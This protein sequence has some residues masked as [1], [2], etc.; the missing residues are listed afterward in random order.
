MRRERAFD[1]IT[2][3]NDFEGYRIYRS[4]DP[5][6]LDPQV[7]YTGTGTRPFALKPIAQFDLING[8]TGIFNYHR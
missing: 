7:I 2:N 6:F 4:T 3:N 1:P 5:S 8:I